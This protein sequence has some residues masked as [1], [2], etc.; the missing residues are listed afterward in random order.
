[1][2]RIKGS[3]LVKTLAWLLLTISVIGFGCSVLA[4]YTFED[5][6]IFE[7]SVNEFMDMEMDVVSN[8][9]CYEA[10]ENTLSKKKEYDLSK[11][12]FY[13]GILKTHNLAD[14]DFYNKAVYA[15]EID[16]FDY[17]DKTAYRYMTFPKE[18]MIPN[19]SKI[20][21]IGYRNLDYYIVF[22]TEQ[23]ADI[24]RRTMS[25]SVILGGA[26]GQT[27]NLNRYE[28]A[29][30]AVLLAYEVKPYVLGAL[31]CFG[32][33]VLLTGVFLFCA[34]GH[35]KRKE[36]IV[37]TFVDSIPFDLL[38]LIV[39]TVE[40][41][42]GAMISEVVNFSSVYLAV[43]VTVIGLI[44]GFIIGFWYLLSVAVRIKSRNLFKNTLVYIVWIWCWKWIKKCFHV[45]KDFITSTIRH[46]GT[47]WVVAGALAF[48]LFLD[49]IV[50]LF[51]SFEFLLLTELPK[52]AVFLTLLK[53]LY[54]MKKL[55]EAEKKIA[56][57]D[58]AYKVDTAKM[59][60][61]QK[62]QGENIN[63]IVDGLNMAVEERMKSERMKT[64]LITNVSHDIKTPLTSIINYVDLL[65]KE[66]IEN[67]NV[68]EY[69]E[70]LERQ[71][72]RLKKLI[73]DL[74]EASKASS[75]ALA[76]S[77]EKIDAGVILSQV[78]GEFEEK[79]QKDDIELIIKKPEEPVE[80]SADGRHLWRVLDN[81]MN[82]IC[83]YSQPHSRVY[84]DLTANE[85][86]ATIVLKNISK[87]QLN[88]SSEELMERFV[89]GD[90]SRNTE[91]HGLGLSIAK[92]LM[93]LMGGTMELFV[94][95]DLFKVILTL[96][97]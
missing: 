87:Y 47:S 80:I 3:N 32:V 7:S 24:T 27:E 92:S 29:A 44:F 95:G 26:L 5:S 36:E 64:E 11:E 76:V 70:V 37:L 2:N 40:G 67:E 33:V 57:G 31:S 25:V 88:V 14:E 53:I 71:S 82:N 52:I 42:I 62:Q 91:G 19:H 23:K 8:H 17:W 59:F 74:V 56:D 85:I 18:E 86:E 48:L 4:A 43:W 13:Y 96:K 9:L 69:L 35:R 61:N 46:I 20:K 38:T 72:S 34:A 30:N 1:M 77:M 97:K 12:G 89:R 60:P 66:N 83:K 68:Q 78:V 63:H 84:I 10:L 73:E 93:E 6:G 75:G 15:S 28:L 51:C 41:C 39:V 45:C 50:L 49:F 94:D 81:L 16:N 54:D 55:Q 22:Y 65:Q 90:A 21:Q 79:L 58:L